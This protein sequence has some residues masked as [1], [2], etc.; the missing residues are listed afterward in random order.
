MVTVTKI[1]K[2]LRLLQWAFLVSIVVYAALGEAA[3]PRPRGADPALSYIF[4]MV[5][6]GIVG[7]IFVVR[8]TLVLQA[9]AS[10]AAR[11]EDS[12]SLNHWRT[13]HIATYVLCESLAL[14]GL[15]L[16]FHGSPLQQSALYYIGGFV[17]IAFFGPRLP[18][19]SPS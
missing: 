9:A 16:R 12:L 15:V 8:R 19:P 18:K 6:V 3:G 1:L 7:T 14:F 5:A 13:G 11:P 17:L 10:L 2:T 4:S